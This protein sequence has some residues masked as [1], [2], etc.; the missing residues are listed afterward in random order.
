MYLIEINLGFN[1]HD[2]SIS[3]VRLNMRR[4]QFKKNNDEKIIFFHFFQYF[5]SNP[6]SNHSGT[7]C[8]SSDPVNF[9]TVASSTIFGLEKKH[10]NNEKYNLLVITFWNNVHLAQSRKI[11]IFYHEFLDFRKLPSSPNHPNASV[12]VSLFEKSYAN[13]IF[14]RWESTLG[15]F[16]IG[17]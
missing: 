9:S 2:D 16:R 5:A 1:F 13:R 17:T 12:H 10:W 3:W 11:N 6:Y 14:H 8:R 4:H 15:I 7:G